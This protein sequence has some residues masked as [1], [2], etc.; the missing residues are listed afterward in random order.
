MA[1]FCHRK[2]LQ[3]WETLSVI[4][5]NGVDF[6]PISADLRKLHLK[7]DEYETFSRVCEIGVFTENPFNGKLR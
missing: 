2:G 3:I 1:V 4:F 7:I 6:I 5:V